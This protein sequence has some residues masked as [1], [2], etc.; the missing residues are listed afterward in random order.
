MDAAK[1]NSVG[2]EQYDLSKVLTSRSDSP[3]RPGDAGAEGVLS[4]DAASGLR[5]GRPEMAKSPVNDRP[6]KRP[7][8]VATLIEEPCP[9]TLGS[10]ELPNV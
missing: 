9:H 8:D 2:N 5:R 4:A 6:L 1:N 7:A 10:M 3:H